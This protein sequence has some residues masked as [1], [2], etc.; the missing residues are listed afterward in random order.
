MENFADLYSDYLI[1]STSYTT[2]TGMSGLLN[3]K[4]DKVTQELSKRDYDSKFLWQR[5]KL[6]VEELT[7]SK[8]LITLSFDDSIEEKRYTDD[9]ELNCWHFD[10][11]FGKSVRGVNFLTGLLEVGGMRLPVGVEFIK[12]D[13]W[14]TDPK[15]G[16]SKRKSSSTKNELFRKMLRECN[17]KMHFDYVLADSWYSSVENM[18]CC[19]EEQKR[20]FIMALKSNRIVALS[21]K[22]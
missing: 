10:H 13:F 21:K 1:C 8:E 6:Y 17:K 2:A 11:S 7:Q 20:N 18:I 5:V 9:S 12:K 16:K 3:I 4:H 19:K 22:R 15:T 14:V